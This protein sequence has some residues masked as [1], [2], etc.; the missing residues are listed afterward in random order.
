MDW[1][2]AM[3]HITYLN[4]LI[5]GLKTK[6]CTSYYMRYLGKYIFVFRFT[7]K[8][9]LLNSNVLQNLGKVVYC[10]LWLSINLSCAKNFYFPLPTTWTM[11]EPSMIPSLSSYSTGRWFWIEYNRS[12][13]IENICVWNRHSVA[14][15][16]IKQ[17]LT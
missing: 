17:I 5:H 2:I 16:N 3:L 8:I 12:S 7:K 4:V 11:L 14:S 1:R 9:T 15:K 10:D 6:L 13:V